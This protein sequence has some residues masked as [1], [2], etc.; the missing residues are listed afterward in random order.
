MGTR[1]AGICS[2]ELTAPL[3]HS[4]DAVEGQGKLNKI[5]MFRVFP[6]L[7]ISLLSVLSLFSPL[8]VLA[9]PIGTIVNLELT[10]TGKLS[11]GSDATY[12]YYLSVDGS[13]NQLEGMCISYD[14]EIDQGESWIAEVT[15]VTGSLQQE[16]AW[17]FNDANLSILA[18]ND[19]QAIDDQWAAWEIFSVNAQNATPPDAGAAT[20]LTAA[21]SAVA[22]GAEPES[23]YQQYIIYVPQSGWPAGKDVPQDFLGYADF[24]DGPDVPHAPEPSSLILLG[25][26]LL[27]FVAVRARLRGRRDS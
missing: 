12:P 16:A 22:L 27:S 15:A 21:E 5:K 13:S 3:Q 23:F 11:Y 1:K 9:D 7:S 2:R 14:N 24:Q 26:G 19:A 6:I 8:K 20:Q 17:L 10:G 25:S 18:G 4:E